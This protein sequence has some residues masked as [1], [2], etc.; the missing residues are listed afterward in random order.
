MLA[1]QGL[2]LGGFESVNN[3]FRL[4]QV[5]THQAQILVG[6][7]AWMPG[8]LQDEMRAGCWYVMAASSHFL[9]QCIFGELCNAEDCQLLR[10]CLYVNSINI[11]AYAQLHCI[12][13]TMC[14]AAQQVTALL[15]NPPGAACKLELYNGG[16]LSVAALL[17][18]EQSC[19]L[20]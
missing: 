5:K 6:C 8:Q 16:V 19:S 10:V 3:L 7:S 2:Y 13:K 18:Q 17:E 20:S 9:H 12:V 11:K 15:C 14:S 1:L 4:G